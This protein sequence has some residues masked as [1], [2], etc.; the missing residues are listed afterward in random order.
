MT[1]ISI[2]TINLNDWRG[3][4]DSIQSVLS[5]TLRNQVEYIVIDGLSKDGSKDIIDKYASH[6]EKVCIEKDSGV[7]DA[8]NKGIDLAMGQY[9]YFLNS[10]DVFASDDV[11]GAVNRAISDLSGQHNIICG[12][13]KLG[14]Q[15]ALVAI[16][17]L[18]PWIP[19]QGAFVKTEVLKAYRFDT[20][21]K[22]YGDLDLWT[23]MKSGND[24][25]VL[26]ID[27][28]IGVFVSGT[29]AM[30]FNRTVGCHNGCSQAK[31]RIGSCGF[32]QL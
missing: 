24:Y 8:M 23:R 6:I 19:H 10:G 29:K 26:L 27:Q 17:D 30:D 3:L 12:N 20:T 15:G 4:E 32:F 13:V 7:F 25:S 14:D 2:V 11:L 5:Q 16:A 22:I 1:K 21:F 28:L 18:T 9:I 31:F